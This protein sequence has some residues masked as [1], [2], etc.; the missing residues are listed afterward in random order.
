M[1]LVENVLLGDEWVPH[2]VVR[3]RGDG[4][5]LFYSLS[6]GLFGTVSLGREVRTQIVEH[7]ARNWMRFHILSSDARGDNFRNVLE[8]V[9]EMSLPETFGTTCEL[10]AAGELFQ[11]FIQ[12][13]RDGELL[14]QFGNMAEQRVIRL[15]FSGDLAGGHFDI[16]EQ[17]V[18]MSFDAEDVT[19]LPGDG[20]SLLGRKKRR[21]RVTDRIRK[22]TEKRR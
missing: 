10:E 12:V 3:M 4:G 19:S 17:I 22:K 15:K 7:V 14:T 20:K 6:Y 21:V 13:F 16:L 11:H 2:R 8:Y 1:E 5:C 18:E 9:A